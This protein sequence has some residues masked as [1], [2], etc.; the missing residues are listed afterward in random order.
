[1]KRVLLIT[2]I[3]AILAVGGYIMVAKFEGENPTLQV[4]PKPSVVGRQLVISVHV[5]DRRS[6]IKDLRAEFVQHEKT[7]PVFYE[8]YPKGTYTLAERLQ[9][10]PASLGLTD[11]SALLRLEARD[12]SWRTNRTA[13]EAAVTVDT[14]PPQVTVLSRFHYLNQG[15]AGLIVYRV[16]EELNTTGVTV[17]D[18]WFPGYPYNDNSYVCFFAVPHDASTDTKVTLVADDRGNN[19][20]HAGFSYRIKPKKFRTD[21]LTIRDGFLQKVMPYFMD[22]DSS[23]TGNLID[24]FL[25]VNR[26]LRQS[27]ADQIAEICRETRPEIL[28]SGPFLR[29][30]NAKTMAGFADRR[31]YTYNGNEIDRQYHLGVDLASIAMSP[32]KAANRGRV[33]FS[34]EL[35]IYG[36]T[37][38]LDHGCG[39]HSMYSHLSRVDVQKG[40]LV[41]KDALLGTTGHSGLAGGDHLH[42]SMLVSG[43]FVNPIEWWDPHWIQDNVDRKMALVNPAAG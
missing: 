16:S 33:I 10:E 28:W 29:L 31:I 4:V 15:G 25:R 27:N 21:V 3:V 2:L 39:L 17:G 23:L 34:G 1:M 11:G 24:I 19:R 6:G 30:E 37:V 32:V 41:E 9:T 13:L 42:F 12:Y 26:A 8:V 20:A 5:E 18:R 36:N 35:G 43:T 7:V 40:S 22:R 14:R 38:I